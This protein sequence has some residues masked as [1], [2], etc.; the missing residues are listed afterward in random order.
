MEYV[1]ADGCDLDF[2]ALRICTNFL[3][4]VASFSPTVCGLA[5]LRLAMPARRV[6]MDLR[7][8]ALRFVPAGSSDVAVRARPPA[9]PP[10]AAPPPPPPPA[11]GSFHPAGAS[12]CVTPVLVL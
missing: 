11:A 10:A 9:A 6:I 3:A 5:V 12:H 1:H 7:A 2:S 4:R 8:P